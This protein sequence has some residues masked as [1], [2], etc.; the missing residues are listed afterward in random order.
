MLQPNQPRRGS[1]MPFTG[2]I[3]TFFYLH[4]TSFHAK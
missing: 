3:E 4:Q 1:L 2:G